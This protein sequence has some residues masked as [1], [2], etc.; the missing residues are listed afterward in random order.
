M[1]GLTNQ[2]INHIPPSARIEYLISNLSIRSKIMIKANQRRFF[3]ILF[4]SRN[5]LGRVIEEDVL[6][7]AEPLSQD[8]LH[9]CHTILIVFKDENGSHRIICS[10]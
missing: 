7:L 5:R 8:F 6:E 2:I 4:Q 10:C 1:R 3:E 9:R